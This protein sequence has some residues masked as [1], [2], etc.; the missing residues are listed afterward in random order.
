MDKKY[1]LALCS[2]ADH[3]DWTKD[4][5]SRQWIAMQPDA[6]IYKPVALAAMHWI[7]LACSCTRHDIVKSLPARWES[8]CAWKT[9]PEIMM[10]IFMKS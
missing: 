2:H 5:P 9:M 7:R 4:S 3:N 1:R 8:A 10:L 6:V